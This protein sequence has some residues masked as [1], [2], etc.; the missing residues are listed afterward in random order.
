MA[1]RR[2][3]ERKAASDAALE[4]ADSVLTREEA[5][6]QLTIARR[7][8]EQLRSATLEQRLPPERWPVM[9]ALAALDEA[10]RNTLA[11]L[12]EAYA[13]APRRHDPTAQRLLK[14]LRTLRGG[15]E[16]ATRE[17]LRPKR[18]RSGATK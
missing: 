2:S 16:S 1:K 6:H 14:A 15:L 13:H 3:T 18:G 11:Q 9:R 12:Q 4:R 10:A 5:L 17:T 8:S 7:E